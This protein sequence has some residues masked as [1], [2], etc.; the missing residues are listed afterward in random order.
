MD[1]YY[2]V[3]KIV[4]MKELNIPLETIIKDMSHYACIEKYD[5]HFT[6]AN[7]GRRVESIYKSSFLYKRP[8]NL[9]NDLGRPI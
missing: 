3:D 2:A 1:F 6:N 8:V 5:K 9:L 7:S 4:E